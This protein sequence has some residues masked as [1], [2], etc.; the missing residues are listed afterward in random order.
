MPFV[1]RGRTLALC[2]TLAASACRRAPDAPAAG[3]AAPASPPA[4]GA[5]A[6]ATTSSTRPASTARIELGFEADAQG[7]IPRGLE[8]R[9]FAA[10]SKFVLAVRADDLAAGTPLHVAWRS[11]AGA[12]LASET[13]AVTAGARSV[14]FPSP[15]TSAWTSGSYKVVVDIDGRPAGE[16]EFRVDAAGGAGS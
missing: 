9:Q 14:A 4:A 6:P 5:A 13:R 15:D 11:A 2:L 12:E 1:R 10:A 7:A 8:S 3:V 16:L